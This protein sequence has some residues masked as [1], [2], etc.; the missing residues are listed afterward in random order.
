MATAGPRCRR[1]R[2]AAVAPRTIGARA[3]VAP[4][5][6]AH[7]PPTV[8]APPAQRGCPGQLR[9]TFEATADVHRTGQPPANRI[10]TVWSYT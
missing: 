6:T 8:Q 9:W 1:W 7:V 10:P 3:S 2:R 4:S 5:R